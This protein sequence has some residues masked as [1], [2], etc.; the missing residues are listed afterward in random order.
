M[1]TNTIAKRL[2]TD[3]D[4]K[5]LHQHIDENIQSLDTVADIDFTNERAASIQ[6]EGRK[7]AIRVLKEILEPFYGSEESHNDAG[8][9]KASQ[10]GV[11]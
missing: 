5:I 3:G 11:L 9:H 8:K 4:W 10:T 7:E 2:E 1:L 6:A